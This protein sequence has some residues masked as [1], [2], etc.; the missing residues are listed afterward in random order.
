MGD[1]ELLNSVVGISH[2]VETPISLHAA[3]KQESF[4]LSCKR[5][6]YKGNSTNCTNSE[7]RKDMLTIYLVDEK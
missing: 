5:C 6:K 4:S 3:A 7:F 1:L 2:W